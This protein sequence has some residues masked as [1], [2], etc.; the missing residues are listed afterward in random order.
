MVPKRILLLLVLALSVAACAGRQAPRTTAEWQK[1]DGTPASQA[2]IDAASDGCSAET[3]SPGAGGDDE[4]F[5]H[6]EWAV[7]MLACMERK[8]LKRVEVPAS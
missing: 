7:E 6:I 2:D 5:S 8:G 1:A 3:G 4:R